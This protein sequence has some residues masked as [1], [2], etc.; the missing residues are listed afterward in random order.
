V[1]REPPG[2]SR[3]TTFHRTGVG[4]ATLRRDGFVSINVGVDGGTM[5]TRAFVFLGDTLVLNA[6]ASQGSVSVEALDLD[7]K[8][9]DGF[10]IDASVT[11]TKDDIRQ[12][13]AVAM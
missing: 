2:L 5:T 3:Q 4:L 6:D 9:I 10:G 1:R 7:G 11:L 13:C 8:P 12:S